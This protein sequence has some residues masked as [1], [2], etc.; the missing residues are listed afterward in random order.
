MLKE[1]DQ[2]DDFIRMHLP[3]YVAVVY[4]TLIFGSNPVLAQS[5]SDTE[6]FAEARTALDKHHNC[7][8]A[9][10]ALS[11][12][13]ESSRTDPVWLIYMA[14][15]LDCLGKPS[16]AIR[17]YTEYDKVVP[18]QTSVLDRIGELRYE[19]AK[20][21]E[22][23]SAE[24][25]SQAAAA[26]V[27]DE[28]LS[29]GALRDF[30]RNVREFTETYNHQTIPKGT[31]VQFVVQGWAEVEVLSPPRVVGIADCTLTFQ[32]AKVK[33]KPQPDVLFVP[34]AD[35]DILSIAEARPDYLWLQPERG[36][37]DFSVWIEGKKEQFTSRKFFEYV[38]PIWSG[39]LENLL[40]SI[41]AACKRR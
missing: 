1:G 40:Q 16:E 21:R 13:S 17:Y 41:V 32:A 27:V 8:M 28:R 30:D 10:S 11:R 24:R 22:R 5:D 26:Q 23:E 6:H 19:I 3:A 31:R 39:R 38:G 15:V 37:A 12:V 25:D 9:Y 35:V 33:G 34:L 29:N 4:M 36:R 7:K 14:R 20:T 2:M 18:G